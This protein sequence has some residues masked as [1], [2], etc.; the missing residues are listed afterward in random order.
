MKK[1]IKL[2]L[3]F[4]SLLMCEYY[5]YGQLD[6][7]RQSNDVEIPN[8]Q[9]YDFIRYGSN[10]GASLYTGTVNASIPFYTYKDKD[11]E[12]P[13]SFDYASNGFKPN[14]RAGDVGLGWTLNVGGCITREVKGIPDD[15]QDLMTHPET[16]YPRGFWYVYSHNNFVYNPTLLSMAIQDPDGKAHLFRYYGENQYEFE[17]DIFHFNFMGYSGSFHLWHNGEVKVYNTNFNADELQLEFYF[18]NFNIFAIEIKT[19]NGY[20]YYFGGLEM[21]VEY[22]VSDPNWGMLDTRTYNTWKLYKITSA[23]G[24]K[25]KFEYDSPII[26]NYSTNQVYNFSPS[27]IHSINIFVNYYT[28]DNSEIN[29]VSTNVSRIFTYPLSKIKID[30]AVEIDFNYEYTDGEKAII[31]GSPSNISI[32]SAKYVQSLKLNNI[33]VK[34]N[35][36]DTIKSCTVSYKKS[37]TDNIYNSKI[38]N[39]VYFLEQLN[40]SGEGVYDFEYYDRTTKGFPCLGTFS[41]DHWGYYNG[42][43]DDAIMNFLNFLTY[44]SVYTES[45]NTI[46]REP[47]FNFAKMGMLQK[48]TYPTG[49]YSILEYESNTYYKYVSREISGMAPG[50]VYYA[51]QLLNCA[52]TNVLTGG[53]RIKKITN[54]SHEQT[55]LSGKEYVYEISDGISSGIRLNFP[56]YGIKYN[57]Q[58]MHYQ[59]LVQYYSLHDHFGYN[60]TH[61]EYSKVTEI[62]HDNSK[63]EYNFTSSNNFIDISSAVSGNELDNYLYRSIINSGGGYNLQTCTIFGNGSI[64]SSILIPVISKQAFRGKL[65]NK[66]Y[67]S[68]TNTPLKSETS[69]YNY[70]TVHEYDVSIIV[71]ERSKG[72]TRQDFN[73]TLQSV[74]TTDY[75]NGNPVSTGTSYTYNS[76]GQIATS[77]VTDSKGDKIVTKHTYVTDLANAAGIHLAMLDNNVINEPIEESVYI[78]KAGTVNEQL[79]EW[80]KYNYYQPNGSQPSLIRLQSVDEY[81]RTTLS[82]IQ[83]ASFVHDKNGRVLQKTDINGIKTSY[84]WGYNGLYPIAKIDNCSLSQIK[85]ISGLENIETQPIT[86]G[87]NTYETALRNNNNLPEAEVTTLEYFPFVGLKSMTDPTGKVT[88]YNYNATGKLKSILDDTNSLR[89]KFYYSTDDKIQT[90]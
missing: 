59:G 12:I 86:G 81:D 56:R 29:T 37:K 30:D 78:I 3:I 47:D 58:S 70:N 75:F 60:G 53:M 89:N 27:S 80:R 51:P 45:I 79:V 9:T 63:I 85:G 84:L 50:G 68:N 46:L 55:A 77:T 33:T 65:T 8:T 24:R 26:N 20:T 57:V 43:S 62:N 40:I 1:Q 11:F 5:C 19:G 23:N 88:H 18:D 2:L 28:G 87:I 32:D 31:C 7:S 35:L 16:A 82:W 44:D 25:V 90:P 39:V 10:V 6:L 64:V 74:S 69:V 17:P 13:I 49:G 73:T 41:V 21:E 52:N 42:R 14:Q 76:H 61:I 67:Y 22:T 54:Y 4:Y 71:G 15:K 72:S 34:N 66:I 48:I 36:Q 83:A 38:K